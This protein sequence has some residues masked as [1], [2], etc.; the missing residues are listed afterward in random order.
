MR[1]LPSLSLFPQKH[2]WASPLGQKH[3]MAALPLLSAAPP[4]A[5]GLTT[6]QPC[7]HCAAGPQKE[8]PRQCHRLMLRDS[9]LLFKWSA[10]TIPD[11]SRT[12]GRTLQTTLSVTLKGLATLSGKIKG[13]SDERCDNY[14]D[15]TIKRE[16]K[17]VPYL[18]KVKSI[19][20]KRRTWF[21]CYGCLGRPS[22]GLL[23]PQKIRSVSV[24]NPLWTWKW[25]VLWFPISARAIYWAI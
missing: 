18:L 7:I 5:A 4:P 22:E 6:G 19:S 9:S 3:S 15:T 10:V 14:T 8:V 13:K 16:K 25:L 17:E 12:G 2:T 23:R 21:R 1:V 20:V 24:I 11:D